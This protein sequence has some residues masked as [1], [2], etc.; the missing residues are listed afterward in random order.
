MEQATPNNQPPQSPAFMPLKP[1]E[2]GVGQNGQSNPQQNQS[3]RERQQKIGQR[4]GQNVVNPRLAQKKQMR[5]KQKSP[6][7]KMAVN[8]AKSAAAKW[9][10]GAT[11]GSMG[12]GGILAWWLT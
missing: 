7:S 4:M 3:M 5:N 6:I 8:E 10:I 11:V 9:I 2:Q 1:V 12:T